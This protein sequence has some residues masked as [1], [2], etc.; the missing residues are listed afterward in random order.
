[1]IY[2]FFRYESEDESDEGEDPALESL[3]AAINYQV[4]VNVIM[5]MMASD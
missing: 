2:I 1:M 3:A 4:I 5:C